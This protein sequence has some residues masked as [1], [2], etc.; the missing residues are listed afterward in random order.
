MQRIMI[1]GPC[2]SGKS[3]LAARLGEQLGIASYHLDQ[4]SF[5][6]G[7]VE[8]PDAEWR[9]KLERIVATQ[10]W[11]IDGNDAATMPLRLERADTI[12]FLD[13]SPARC[14]WR[15]VKRVV[16]HWGRTRAD[17]APECP[18]RLNIAF[19]IYVA[20]WNRAPRRRIEAQLAGAEDRIVR[21]GSPRALEEWLASLACPSSPNR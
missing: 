1:V 7:W 8:L 10:A 2:G 5:A 21:L 19:L 11:V 6:P 14:V 15:V 18:E 20:T 9:P 13:F 17:M 12:V 16:S 3:T 4:L